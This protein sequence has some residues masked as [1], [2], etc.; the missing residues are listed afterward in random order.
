[1]LLQKFNT[2]KA[3]YNATQIL[4]GSRFFYF[5]FFWLTKMLSFLQRQSTFFNVVVH[6]MAPLL[7]QPS[8]TIKNK[9]GIFVVQ[10]FDDS[11]TI[12]SDYFEHD[13]R[14]WL[15]EPTTKDIFLDIGAN[16]GLYAILAPTHYSYSVVHAFE[17]NKEVFGTLQENIKLNNLTDKVTVHNSAIGRETAVA[18]L[19]VDP[20][21][22]GGGKVTSSQTGGQ[23]TIRIAPLDVILHNVDFKRISFIKIDTEGF[24]CEVLAGMKKVLEGMPVGSCLMIET[25]DQEKI[26]ELVSPYQFSLCI[27][28]DADYLFKKF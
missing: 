18:Y 9:S 16:R 1:M 28:K 21:H 13:I 14:D 23:E 7:P 4:S 19:D 26:I 8:F 12:C 6:K 24:E 10:P 2:I 5:I 17:P 3:N 15:H 25:A 22:K 20:L 27:A 11:T